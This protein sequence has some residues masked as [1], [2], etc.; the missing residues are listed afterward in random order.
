MAVIGSGA[1]AYDENIVE[2]TLLF[3]A[4]HGE[5]EAWAVAHIVGKDFRIVAE[6]AGL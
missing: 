3:Q 2:P 6:P 4:V 5:L 1:E